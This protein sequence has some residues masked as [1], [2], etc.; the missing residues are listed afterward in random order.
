MLLSIFNHFIFPIQGACFFSLYRFI[1][2]KLMASGYIAHAFQMQL[3]NFFPC[4]QNIGP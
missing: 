1:H 3:A 4:I 2:K